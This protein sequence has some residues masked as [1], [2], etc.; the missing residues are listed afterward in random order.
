MNQYIIKS[1]SQYLG[2]NSFVSSFLT[3]DGWMIA[4]N[5]C[6]K[7]PSVQAAVRYLENNKITGV[8]CGTDS[9]P[10]IVGPK[11]GTYSPYSG[12]LYK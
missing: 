9:M 10:Y 7:F 1:N 6:L 11:G 5:S 3:P 4:A 12:R 2:E 8:R